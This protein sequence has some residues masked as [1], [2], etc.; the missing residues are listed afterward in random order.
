MT[1]Q[2]VVKTDG[3]APER[4]GIKQSQYQFGYI[5]PMK[6]V[7][8]TRCGDLNAVLEGIDEAINVGLTPVKINTVLISGI[9]D[10]EIRDLIDFTKRGIDADS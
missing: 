5:R 10:D 2:S 9:N 7:R 1:K 8:I 4:S 3:K 6:F